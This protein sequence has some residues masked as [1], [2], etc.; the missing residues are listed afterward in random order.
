MV[1]Y[2]NIAYFKCSSLYVIAYV[3]QIILANIDLI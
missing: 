3:A 2:A 1:Y